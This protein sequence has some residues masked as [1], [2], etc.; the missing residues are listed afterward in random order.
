MQAVIRGLIKRGHIIRR[1][2]RDAHGRFI[3]YETLVF[4]E[5]HACMTTEM[6]FTDIGETDAGNADIRKSNPNNTRVNNTNF[7]NT[8]TKSEEKS[9]YFYPR[10]QGGPEADKIAQRCALQ[11]ISQRRKNKK[12]QSPQN[13]VRFGAQKI[14]W[15]FM[16]M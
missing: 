6:P 16:R 9:S 1:K 4:E 15:I 10:T 11:T 7:N 14:F 8:T 3:G 2:I 5:P 12:K 13:A